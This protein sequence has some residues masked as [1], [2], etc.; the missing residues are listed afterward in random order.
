LLPVLAHWS[1]PAVFMD[2]DSWG[3]HRL[4]VNL[5]HGNGYSW[6]TE[7]PYTPNTY[8]PPG[9]PLFLCSLYGLVGCSVP[10]AILVQALVGAGTVVATFW[11]AR[12]LLGD[13]RSALAAAAVQAVDPLAIQQSNFLLT[14]GY[15]VLLVLLAALLVARY[16]HSGRARLLLGAGMLLGMGILIHPVLLFAPGLLLLAPLFWEHTRNIRQL[17]VAGLIMVL[18][19]VPAALWVA[20][21]IDVADY[22]G[23]SCVAAVNLLK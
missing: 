12:A 13:A 1:Y 22:A 4:A 16:G 15:T 11:W 23:I 14:E 3:Y 5:L 21:N 10:C 2:P 8:R 19:L 6:E 9:L 7:P 18:A 20:R 17:V